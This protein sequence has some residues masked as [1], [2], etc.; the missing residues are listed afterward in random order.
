MSPMN[1]KPIFADMKAATTIAQ[2]ITGMFGHFSYR[3]LGIMMY[4]VT[5]NFIYGAIYDARNPT[6][7]EPSSCH[8]I[9]KTF[10]FIIGIVTKFQNFSDYN[11]K[12]FRL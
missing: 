12:S 7:K 2:E 1:R 5:A 3:D 11:R 6:Q 4:N 10:T 9:F 8:M